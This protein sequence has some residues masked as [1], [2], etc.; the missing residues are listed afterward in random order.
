[1]LILSLRLRL[2]VLLLAKIQLLRRG[3]V[4][5]LVRELVDPSPTLKLLPFDPRER[6]RCNA[7]L[8]LCGV[9]AALSSVVSDHG[10]EAPMELMIPSS[11]AEFSSFVRARLPPRAKRTA[12]PAPL[13]KWLRGGASSRF[14]T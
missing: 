3:F 14:A 5:E 10:L 12:I 7:D 13:R 2:L 1:M 9:A 8:A 11:V 6:K 4:R